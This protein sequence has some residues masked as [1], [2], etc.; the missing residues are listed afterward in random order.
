MDYD[1]VLECGVAESIKKEEEEH[2]CQGTERET[3]VENSL[4]RASS[5]SKWKTTLKF[6][7]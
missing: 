4:D 2:F 1:T 7:Q 3:T 6:N 5:N